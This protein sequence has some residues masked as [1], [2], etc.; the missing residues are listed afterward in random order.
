MSKYSVDFKIR[1]VRYH[2]QN[3]GGWRK[4]GTHFGIDHSTVRKW[5]AA[6]L[7]HGHA[8]LSKRH[9]HY[10]VEE[11]LEVLRRMEEENWS[12]RQAC[13]HFNIPARTTLQTWIRRYNEGGAD[14]LINR[15]RGRAMSKPRKPAPPPGRPVAGMTP[16]E[17]AQELE[18]LRAEN[19]YLKKLDALIQEKKSAL[20]KKH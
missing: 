19:A 8:A 7:L 18:Y 17:I 10:T 2:I 12:S 3:G 9:R 20:K 4:T 14:A 15:H 1:V 6:Y 11:K 13:A 16:E 5:H